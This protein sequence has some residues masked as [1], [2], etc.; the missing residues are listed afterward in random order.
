V[1]VVEAVAAGYGRRLARAGEVLVA[2]EC[3][4]DGCGELVATGAGLAFCER[5][6]VEVLED[7]RPLL[8][9]F[10][11]L[12]A[13]DQA[14][15]LAMAHALAEPDEVR[16]TCQGRSSHVV[17]YDGRCLDCGRD[18]AALAAEG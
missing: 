15:V 11:Q 1:A 10:A 5:C 6:E 7:L 18:L 14:R 3:V 12:G 13:E 16:A 9:G 4:R 8:E 2:G 17:D